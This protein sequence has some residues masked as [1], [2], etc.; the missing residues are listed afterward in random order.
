MADIL[1]LIKETGAYRTLYGD[2]KRNTLSH[3]YLF[4]SPDAEYLKE[5]LKIFAKLI[6]CQ[7]ENPCFACRTCKL[8]DQERFAD[9]LIYPKN[10]SSVLS[11]DVNSLIEESY[12]KPIENDKKVFILSNAETMNTQ[13]Q[14]K[15]LKTLEEPPKNVHILIGA[16]SEFPLLPTVKS[17]VKKLEIPA[18]SKEQLFNA[19][20]EECPDKDKLLS[21]ISC[22]DGTLG[23]AKALYSDENL[24]TAIDLAIDMIVNMQSS[25]Q[26][27]EY[28][29]KISTLKTDLTE[30]LSV[31]ELLLRD[32]LVY[33]QG[34]EGLA[35]N[36][37]ALEQTKNA[38]GYNTGAIVNALEKITESKKRKKFNQSGA[39]LI[40]WLLFQ[41]LEGKYK[42]QKL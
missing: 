37:K 27:L 1:S 22:G 6:C 16:T 21:A 41:V 12:L 18:F 9:V 10:S 13:A 40:E 5:Y 8:I 7:S 14:N 39:M 42:W 3:A 33:R 35:L 25:A 23:K 2:K 26:V 36:K 32:L 19:L 15:L 11:E 29:V 30:F 4:I 34:K 24:S 31:L 28:S 20:I 17:R 38:K